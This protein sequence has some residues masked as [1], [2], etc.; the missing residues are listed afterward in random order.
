VVAGNPIDAALHRV[1]EHATLCRSLS[2]GGRVLASGIKG[3]RR[4][5]IGE[6]DG[7]EQSEAA[8]VTYAPA[9]TE[10]LQNGAHVGAELLRVSGVAGGTHQVLGDD[11]LQYGSAGGDGDRV[12]VVGKAVDEGTGAARD[13]V[14]DFAGNDDGAERHVSAGDSLA[15][16]DDVRL[17]A[18]MIDGEVSAGAPEAGHDFVG[19]HEESMLPAGFR[20]GGK[21]IRRRNGGTDGRSADGFEDEGGDFGTLG[22]ENGLDFGGEFF[23]AAVATVFA[24]IAIGCADLEGIGKEGQIDFAAL[25]VAGDRH[26]S[27]GCTMVGLFAAEEFGATSLAD[28]NLVLASQFQSGFGGFGSA[29]GKED[30]AAF[31]GLTGKIEDLGGEFFGGFSCELGTV[32]EFEIRQLLR[33]RL[34]NRRVA[35]SDEVY[36]GTAGE[37]EVAVPVLVPDPGTLA[38]GGDGVG[39]TE[40]GRNEQDRSWWRLSQRRSKR[41]PG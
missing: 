13:G 27:Q 29:R 39:L 14:D 5:G 16:D 26:R 3:L 18:P 37:I 38:S 21:V 12:S 30:C 9:L 41:G 24:P 34:R 6:F 11:F 35:V 40:G 10:S 31:K 15:G 20:Y 4:D 33:N 1:S 23:G 28:F 22:G 19:D 17:H 2:D 8:N 32:D 36:S 25:A 7:P